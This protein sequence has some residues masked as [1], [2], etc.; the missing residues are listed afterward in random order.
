MTKEQEAILKQDMTSDYYPGELVHYTIHMNE[1]QKIHI[2]T[3][4]DKMPSILVDTMLP[5]VNPE[6][7]AKK[8]VAIYGGYDP[9]QYNVRN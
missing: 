6:S 4:L 1:C 5:N 7:A 8:S 3:G 9:C 2:T